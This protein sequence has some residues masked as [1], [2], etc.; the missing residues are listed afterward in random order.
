M[1]SEK[2]PP[3]LN[4]VYHFHL[5]LPSVLNQSFF[6]IS[7]VILIGCLRTILSIQPGFKRYKIKKS[8]PK[9]FIISCCKSLFLCA[10]F[11]YNLC[12]LLIQDHK[13]FLPSAIKLQEQVF[14]YFPSNLLTYFSHYFLYFLFN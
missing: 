7:E 14:S 2:G 8:S 9:D 3:E 10:G 6:F 12:F 1:I 11:R 13:Y 4:I 5:S